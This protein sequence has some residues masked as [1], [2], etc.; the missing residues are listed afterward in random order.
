MDSLLSEM[1]LSCPS[2]MSIS[3]SLSSKLHFAFVALSA[4][5]PSLPNNS[6]TRLMF[7]P[8]FG[9][10]DSHLSPASSVVCT[11]FVYRRRTALLRSFRIKST[12]L[13]Y[14]C[15]A[16]STMPGPAGVYASELY[17]GHRGFPLWFPEPP[18]DGPIQIGDVGFLHQGRFI[19]LFNAALDKHQPSGAPADHIELRF[20]GLRDTRVFNPSDGLVF[21]PN[22]RKT[23]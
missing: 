9:N 1:T 13:S 15:A 10:P 17:Q 19:R 21:S 18:E 12:A 20:S 5:R 14:T 3:R 22:M 8:Q 4:R 6:L 23:D 2:S 7:T 16:L 11:K